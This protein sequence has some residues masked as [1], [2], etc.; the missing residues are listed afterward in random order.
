[1]HVAGGS[2]FPTALVTTI[3]AV[4][5]ALGI[6]VAIVVPHLTRSQASSPPTPQPTISQSIGSTVA[7][8][9]IPI[10]FS[11]NT[12]P[13]SDPAAVLDAD[14]TTYWSSNLQRTPGAKDAWI[15][16][17]MGV[18]DSFTAMSVT[19]RPR[20][21]GFPAQFRI[22]SSV[23]DNTWNVVPG[24]DYTTDHPYQR[25]AD[26]VQ[27]LTFDEPVQARYFR[28]FATDLSQPPTAALEQTQRAFMLQIAE[29][30]ILRP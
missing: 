26:G 20:F 23:D 21:V 19:P 24:Q 3:G 6:A 12:A 1:V 27:L 13:D 28:L 8:A 29:M 5:V 11:D 22:E 17:D 18:V 15:G 30:Q 4:V 25:S 7:P 14:P 10:A 16:I 9:P 2:G